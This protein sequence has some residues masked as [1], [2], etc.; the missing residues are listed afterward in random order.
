[1]SAMDIARNDKRDG[2]DLVGVDL[3]PLDSVVELAVLADDVDA[4]RLHGIEP[5]PSIEDFLQ[6]R[7]TDMKC[8]IRPRPRFLDDCYRLT[9]AVRLDV[10]AKRPQFLGL[11]GRKK[12]GSGMDRENVAPGSAC[13][14]TVVCPMRHCDC[15]LVAEPGETKRRDPVR[16]AGAR[17]LRR[18]SG[19][20]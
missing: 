14:V 3:D 6:R 19:G 9:L 7:I 17:N 8:A 4:C 2:I 1:M 16:Q 13:G 11:H 5:G 18:L 10:L 20:F 15:S 12:F